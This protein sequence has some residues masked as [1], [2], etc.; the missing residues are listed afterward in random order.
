MTGRSFS[1][2]SRYSRKTRR[3]A[4]KKRA[5]WR[6]NNWSE[7]DRPPSK[8]HRSGGTI[9]IRS[10]HR[11][12]PSWQCS[13]DWNSWRSKEAERDES[14]KTQFSGE[15]CKLAF[16]YQCDQWTR[17]GQEYKTYPMWYDEGLDREVKYVSDAS[18]VLWWRR[19]V[20]GR[21]L[22]MTRRLEI[23]TKLIRSRRIK[24]DASDEDTY[25]M[26]ECVR[27]GHWDKIVL[28]E[29]LRVEMKLKISKDI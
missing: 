24:Y 28:M 25:S 22:D 20:E 14:T 29:E 9:T 27:R 5:E 15:W 1:F 23:A 6:P 12:V 21:E 8:K 16:S 10:S 7:D 13:E 2:T 11:R 17:E 19:N 3:S 26:T 4:D 18:C